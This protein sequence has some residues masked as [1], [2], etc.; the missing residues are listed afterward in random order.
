MGAGGRLLIRTWGFGG[1]DVV[2]VLSGLFFGGST[3]GLRIGWG[4]GSS[5]QTALRTLV[6][7]AGE[8][9]LLEARDGGLVD[10]VGKIRSVTFREDGVEQVDEARGFG[11]LG[12][13]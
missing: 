12:V 13:G 11:G 7:E 6:D 4:G 3:A 5:E 9:D 2:A 10:G 1:C 8:D